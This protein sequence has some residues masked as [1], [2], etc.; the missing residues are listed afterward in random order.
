MSEV[1]CKH[2]GVS[3][4][5]TTAAIV[6]FVV[7]PII[8]ALVLGILTPVTAEGPSA[9]SVI[10]LLPI[11]YFFSAF[12]TLVLAVPAA[13][14]LRKLGLAS[15]WSASGGGFAIGVF[16]L[17]LLHWQPGSG[18]LQTSLANAIRNSLTKGAIIYGATGGFSG[19]VFWL[20]WKCGSRH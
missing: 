6:G 10:G 11:G 19:F 12:V 5:E 3:V 16:V 20:I 8:P 14:G 17:V 15:W 4:K 18:D 9:L 7:V 13:F 2:E 1:D